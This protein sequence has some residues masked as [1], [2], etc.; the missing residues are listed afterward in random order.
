MG[1]RTVDEARQE[2][3]SDAISF[4]P[5]TKLTTHLLGTVCGTSDSCCKL[6]ER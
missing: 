6:E 3:I 5:G 4:V 2:T 1:F